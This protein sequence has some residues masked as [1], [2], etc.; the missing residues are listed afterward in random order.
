MNP[1]RM[2]SW[3]EI[4]IAGLEELG[5]DDG[6]RVMRRFGEMCA[7]EWLKYYGYD[8]EKLSSLDLDEWI[9]LVNSFEKNVRNVRRDGDIIIYELNKGR[10][11]CPLVAEGVIKQDKRLCIICSPNFFEYIFGKVSKRTARAET[12]ESVAMGSNRCVYKI[13]LE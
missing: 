6:K 13:T 7:I 11:V 2:R 10:C 5:V 4:L 9:E 3:I 12:L 1:E 8:T